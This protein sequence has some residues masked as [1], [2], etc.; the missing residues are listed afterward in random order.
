MSQYAPRLAV[1]IGDSLV[2][3]PY[4]GEYTGGSSTAVGWARP[5]GLMFTSV[6]GFEWR[7]L[8][9]SGTTTATFLANYWSAALAVKPRW[10]LIQFGTNDH[11]E[12]TTAE[13]AANLHRMFAEARAQNCEPI[14]ITPP[15]FFY[16]APPPT[17]YTTKVRRP[18]LIEPVRD[19]GIVQADADGVP[20][21]DLYDLMGDH[22]DSLTFDTAWTNLGLKVP[23]GST[24]RTHWNTS[25]AAKASDYIAAALPTVSPSLA[26]YLLALLTEP[27]FATIAQVKSAAGVTVSTY[28]TDLQL[29]VDGVA[30]AMKS[31]MRRNVSLRRYTAERHSLA[32]SATDLV[33]DHRPVVSVVE[34]RLDGATVS[35]ADYEIDLERGVLYN[36]SGW[37]SGRQHIQV[38]YT[39]GYAT[40]PKDLANA[41]IQQSRYVW[42]LHSAGGNRFGEAQRGEA[43]GGSTAFL[44][45]AWQPGVLDVLKSYRRII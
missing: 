8:A 9:V 29:I 37:P 16:A 40:V 1:A 12:M 39:A 18:Y 20:Y 38:D 11:D 28:D 13:Y 14:Y 43:S 15:P 36:A 35:Q 21:V 17:G 33:L 30:A 25:G 42:S 31:Y 45:D 24:D 44:V 5:L 23:S 4:P 19:A 41:C 2:H 7:D 32:Y 3:D 34:V 27:V 26:G 10:M 6:P 22:Y